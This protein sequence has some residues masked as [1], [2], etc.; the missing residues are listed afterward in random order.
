MSPFFCAVVAFFRYRC[1]R[2]LV[3]DCDSAAELLGSHGTLPRQLQRKALGWRWN[4]T[5]GMFSTCPAQSPAYASAF[6]RMEWHS[7]QLA[8]ISWR[9]RAQLW[10]SCISHHASWSPD[11]VARNGSRSSAEYFIRRTQ[12]TLTRWIS[13]SSRRLSWDAKP[14][15]GRRPLLGPAVIK[16][17]LQGQPSVTQS[18]LIDPA[19]PLDPLFE[20]P[21]CPRANAGF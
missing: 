16:S 3:S 13:N 8:A 15:Q 7:K 5:M 20:R 9:R 14:L 10:S 4:D 21:S 6:V 17:G 19:A 12:A 11:P 18:L 2:Q 1:F